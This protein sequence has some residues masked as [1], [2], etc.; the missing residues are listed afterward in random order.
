[1]DADQRIQLVGG[2]DLAIA[3]AKKDTVGFWLSAAQLEFGQFSA[4][5]GVVS[6][7]DDGELD[8]LY[9][10]EVNVIKSDRGIVRYFGSKTT[11]IDKTDLLRQENIADLHIFMK[12][13]F[14]ALAL[15]YQ[16]KPNTQKTLWSPMYNEARIILEDLAA[17]SAIQPNEGEGWIWEGDQEARSTSQLKYNTP[18]DITQGIYK[19]RC[20]FQ[21]V[22]AAEYIGITLERTSQSVNVQ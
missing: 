14:Q 18:S 21:P 1:M 22:G 7:F 15:K 6:S 8:S 10:K 9:D 19:A 20:R 12:N 13:V 4:V 5:N 16:F 2:G 11:I 17:N 3:I